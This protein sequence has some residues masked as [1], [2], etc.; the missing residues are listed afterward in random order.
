MS[1]R[2]LSAH[3]F[4]MK[5][6]YTEVISKCLKKLNKMEHAVYVCSTFL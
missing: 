6:E 5:T 2:I 3:F 1:G 4:K